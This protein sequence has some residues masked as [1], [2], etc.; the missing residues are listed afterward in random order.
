MTQFKRMIEH[1]DGYAGGRIAGALCWDI[2]RHIMVYPHGWHPV[3]ENR[4]ADML[5]DEPGGY[6]VEQHVYPVTLW[7]GGRSTA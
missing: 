7:T 3:S 1:D 4:V 6:V 5:A 2:D